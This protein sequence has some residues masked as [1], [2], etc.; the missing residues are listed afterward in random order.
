MKNKMSS[1]AHISNNSPD[2][3]AFQEHDQ[4]N[5][6]GF[7]HLDLKQTISELQLE[8]M[9]LETEQKR[10]AN[11]SEKV[12]HE[13]LKKISVIRQQSFKLIEQIEKQC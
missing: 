11:E 5:C 6:S 7:W 2:E 4:T 13:R 10:I 12:E 8:R 3:L 9:T 1:T